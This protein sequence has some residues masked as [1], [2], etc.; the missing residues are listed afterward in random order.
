MVD[1]QVGVEAMNPQQARPEANEWSVP[2]DLCHN[3]TISKH[4]G[5]Y[6]CGFKK[7]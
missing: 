1:V 4:V 2:D 6:L 7:D 5:F 3:Q